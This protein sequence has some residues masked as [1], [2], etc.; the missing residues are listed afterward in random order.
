MSDGQPVPCWGAVAES[1][2]IYYI[3]QISL[4]DNGTDYKMDSFSTAITSGGYT[5]MV[6][7]KEVTYS[8]VATVRMSTWLYSI[9]I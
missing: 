3:A 6:S 8:S 2:A 9:E 7:H 1:N 5:G 4:Q